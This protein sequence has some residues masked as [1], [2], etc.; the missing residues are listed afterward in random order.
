M[1]LQKAADDGMAK[2]WMVHV[3]IAG[4]INK[5]TLLPSPDLHISPAHGKIIVHHD[6]STFLFNIW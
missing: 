5:V 4:D 6:F 2:G 1:G 3:G